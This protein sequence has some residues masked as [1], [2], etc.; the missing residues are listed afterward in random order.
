MFEVMLQ[1]MRVP[2][3]RRRRLLRPVD[4]AVAH[5]AEPRRHHAGGDERDVGGA[6]LLPEGSNSSGGG[7]TWKKILLSN[8]AL[9]HREIFAR[10]CS[11]NLSEIC[12]V[13]IPQRSFR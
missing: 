13:H 12:P 1:Q 11:S 5:R 6:R 9:D 7:R 8:Y 2:V 4:G 10:K 3:V